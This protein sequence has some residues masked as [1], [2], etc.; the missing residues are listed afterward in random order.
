VFGCRIINCGWH[1][2]KNFISHFNEL[3]KQDHDLYK[4]V[5]SLPF[6]SDTVWFEE[7]VK[8]VEN[9]NKLFSKEKVYLQLNC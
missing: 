3:N 7:I 5:I 8:E 2:Q 9:S 6:V 1:V 4:K